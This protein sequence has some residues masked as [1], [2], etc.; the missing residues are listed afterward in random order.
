LAVAPHGGGV[1]DSPAGA[2][3]LLP[4]TNIKFI[5]RTKFT[6]GKKNSFFQ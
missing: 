5:K 2:L 4:P 3:S 6:H 1:E